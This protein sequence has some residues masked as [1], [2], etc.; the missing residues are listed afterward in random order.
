[1]QKSFP[2]FTRK[3]QLFSIKQGY[4]ELS[5]HVLPKQ[6]IVLFSRKLKQKILISISFSAGFPCLYPG[7]SYAIDPGERQLGSTGKFHY[8]SHLD[9]F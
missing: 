1:M 4:Y 9:G 3:N 6:N 8:I 5:F 2:H 7:I